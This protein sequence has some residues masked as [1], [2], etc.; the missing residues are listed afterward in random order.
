M[1]DN[2]KILLDELKL[3]RSDVAHLIHAQEILQR[4]IDELDPKSDVSVTTVAKKIDLSPRRVRQMCETGQIEAVQPNP[5]R[6][7]WKIPY[8]ELERLQR[9]AKQNRFNP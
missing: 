8:K 6:G 5:N 7:H 3:L 4:K 2:E 1:S 9:L